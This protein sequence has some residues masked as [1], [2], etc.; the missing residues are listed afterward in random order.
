MGNCQKEKQKGWDEGPLWVRVWVRATDC[1][2]LPVLL[3]T[4]GSRSI[5]LIHSK[6]AQKQVNG[7]LKNHI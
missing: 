3:H 6:V 4:Q 2:E 5:R 7:V 1:E